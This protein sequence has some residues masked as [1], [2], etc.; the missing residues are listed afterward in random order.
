MVTGGCRGQKHQRTAHRTAQLF[1]MWPQIASEPLV[2]RLVLASISAADRQEFI[3]REPFWGFASEEQS[4]RE[5]PL[6][7]LACNF[8]RTMARTSRLAI[9][10][11]ECQHC[12]F[13]WAPPELSFSILC[14]AKLHLGSFGNR[15]GV[16]W[17]RWWNRGRVEVPIW[18]RVVPLPWEFITKC[19]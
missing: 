10:F 7:C 6:M 12:Y 4:S 15:G 19:L 1:C 11:P 9:N 2:K 13:S 5:P 8:R 18:G 3:E 14:V 16:L 17:V